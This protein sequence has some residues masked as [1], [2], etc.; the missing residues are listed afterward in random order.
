MKLLRTDAIEG[1]ERSAQDVIQAAILV[2]AL[3]AEDVPG[4]LDDA[5]S[6]GV[7]P[8]VAA[9]VTQLLLGEVE[10]P[11]AEADHFFD[12][13]Q[14]VGEGERLFGRELEQV[15]GEA[16]SGLWP[17]A[18][19]LAELVDELLDGGAEP[20]ATCWKVIGPGRLGTPRRAC[21]GC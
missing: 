3:D 18:G 19:E 11:P 7:A 20:A 4:L 21:R 8:R 12:L 16:L 2:R 10:A 1:R 9:D 17:D 15:K 14:R 13:D 5:D 6:R